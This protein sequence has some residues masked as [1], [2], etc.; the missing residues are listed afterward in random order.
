MGKSDKRNDLFVIVV[1]FL[2]ALLFEYRETFSLIED[3]TLSYR[4]LLRTYNADPELTSPAEDIVIVY[5]DEEFY[6]EYDKY[7]LRRVD[8]STILVRLKEMGAAVIAVDMLLDFKSA[9]GEDPSLE[10]ALVEAGNVLLV[11]QAQFEN[12]EFVGVN[13]AIDRFSGQTSNGYSNISSNSAISQSIVRLRVYPEIAETG[14]WPFAVEAVSQYLGIEPELVGR[15]LTIGDIEA[16]LDHFNDLYIDYPLL[17]PDGEG[18]TV[19]LHD[20]VGLSAADLLFAE[21][22]EELEELSFLVADK[23]VLI[24]EVA[25]VAHDEFETPV[26]NVYGVEIIANTI[27]TILRSS[28]LQAASFW[29]EG[30]IAFLMLAVMIVSRGIANPLPRNV[31]SF[32]AVLLFIAGVCLAYVQIGLIMSVSYTLLASLLAIIVINAKYYLNEMGQKALIRDAFGQYLSPK[33]VADLVKDPEKLVL[34]GEEREMTAFFSDIA[35]FSSFSEKMTPTELVNALNDYLTSMCSI[36]VDLEGTIDK[37]EGDAIIAFWGAPAV[38]AQ[39]AKLACFASID[40]QR[41]IQEI[42]DRFV[43]EGRPAISVRMGVN[44]GPMVVGNMGSVQRMDY[45]IMGDTVNLA[46]RLEGANKAYGSDIM[47]TDATYRSCEDHVDVRE[48]DLLRVVGKQEAVQVYQLMERKGQLTGAMAD[49]VVE[50]ENALA[51]YK[52]LDFEQAIA[53]Y[54]KCLE[55]V[56]D[57]GPSRVYLNRCESY[58]TSPP[59]KD[60]DGVFTLTEKG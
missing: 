29:L 53:G 52:A 15:T 28:P 59:P 41:A 34:G 58:L 25:E 22:E 8:L 47:I 20:V 42:S 54:K 30:F 26:G 46:S 40:M 24:G 56:P 3:E 5:T 16:S 21:D 6:E 57:D 35:G 14:Q 19:K 37:F 60:W 27:S 51:K 49:M 36:I 32:A 11:S 17:P 31:L 44:T 10:D 39:H 33:V 50:F 23:I 13:Y 48:L 55:I 9:Y 1:I 38:Q 43:K 45:T 7:P 2:V 12:E 4:Q 18:G